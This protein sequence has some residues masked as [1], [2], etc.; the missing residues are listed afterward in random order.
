MSV[1]TS[2]LRAASEAAESWLN[3]VAVVAEF[4]RTGDVDAA[5]RLLL[6]SESDGRH[7]SEEDAKR[8]TEALLAEVGLPS[9]GRNRYLDVVCEL[10]LRGEV[11]RAPSLQDSFRQHWPVLDQAREDLAARSEESVMW[12]DGR[13]RKAISRVPDATHPLIWSSAHEA[14]AGI[15][16]LALEMLAWPVAAADPEEQWPLAEQLL[17]QRWKALALPVDEVAHLQARIRRERVKLVGGQS[18]RSTHPQ[19]RRGVDKAMEARNKWIYQQCRKGRAMPLDAIKAKLA[20]LAPQRGW[21]PIE[22][23]QGLRAAA[24]RYAKRHNKLPIPNRQE[25]SE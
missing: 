17:A 2:K 25:P 12:G 14:A 13:G 16:R 4:G 15:A 21:E 3:T 24:N 18:G 9:F 10:L 6:P 20:R 5:F 8:K 19:V 22:S 11:G 1:D 7:N 23:I